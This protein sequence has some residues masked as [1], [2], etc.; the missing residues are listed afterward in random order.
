MMELEQAW[1]LERN[2]ACTG[3]KTFLTKIEG[4]THPLT[5]CPELFAYGES[6][7]FSIAYKYHRFG[8]HF[9]LELLTCQLLVFKT[10]FI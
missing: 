7:A 2:K 3:Q 8:P 9:I 5:S 1:I 6:Q 10:F 4:I